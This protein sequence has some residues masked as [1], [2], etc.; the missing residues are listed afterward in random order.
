LE[1]WLWNCGKLNFSQ[2][3]GTTFSDTL[4]ADVAADS[5]LIAPS[6]ERE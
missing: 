3:A 4:K 1:D 6:T 5:F 2:I